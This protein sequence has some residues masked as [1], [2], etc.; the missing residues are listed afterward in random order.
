MPAGFPPSNGQHGRRGQAIR[1]P[2]ALPGP[3]GPG[4]AP[5][6]NGDQGRPGRAGRRAVAQGRRGYPD[7][8]YPP[9]DGYG[10]GVNGGQYTPGDQRQRPGRGASSR[11]SRLPVAAR[12]RAPAADAGRAHAGQADRRH[13]VD[14][15]RESRRAR[16]ASPP[17]NV[18]P[19]SAYGP[20]D[21]AYG[22]PGPSSSH[23]DRPVADPRAQAAPPAPSVPRAARVPGG[24]STKADQAMATRSWPSRCEQS[25]CEQSRCEPSQSWQDKPSLARLRRYT[26]TPRTTRL[27]A[28]HSSRSSSTAR[29]PGRPRCRPTTRRRIQ[30]ADPTNSRGSPTTRQLDRPTPRLTGSRNCTGPRPRSPRRASTPT[31]TS[32]S[33]DSVG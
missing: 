17:V 22:P 31:S 7:Y 5:G 19:G 24:S 14:H 26:P 4:S 30:T 29:H 28:A 18:G 13:P 15:R 27:S 12:D 10:Q 3:G 23:Q 20:D 33:N 11:P 25:R 16:V 8:G 2:A 21:P 1:G 32:S 9:A 6:W